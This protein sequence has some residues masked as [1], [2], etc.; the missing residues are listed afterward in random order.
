MKR[1]L[2]VSGA[3]IMAMVLLSV[4]MK[5]SK[6]GSPEPSVKDLP[7]MDVTA[8]TTEPPLVDTPV[9][10]EKKSEKIFVPLDRSQ[11][12]VI[13]KPFGIYID[14]QTSPVTSEKFR[15]YHTGADFE[16]FPEERDNDVPVRAI[17]PGSL[18]VKR[19]ATGYG[20]VIVERCVLAGQLVTVV[21]G[22][23]A[24]ESVGVNVGENIDYGDVIGL[25][26]AGQSVETDGER[27][28]LHLGIHKGSAL[29]I[30]GYIA[31]KQALSDWIDPCTLLCT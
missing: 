8:P 7:R 15:G 16:T 10:T 17:C 18:I 11:E 21:Y 5:Q 26:G 2:W 29:D 27:K 4:M 28:H 1:F 19:H 30:R 20:G 12:R 9:V 31:I 24:L 13:K 22:H 3:V 25:L 14:P 6:S 23:L